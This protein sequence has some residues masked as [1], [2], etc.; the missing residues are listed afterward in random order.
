MK[1]DLSAQLNVITE[2]EDMTD[3]LLCFLQAIVPVTAV[4]LLAYQPETAQFVL[5]ASRKSGAAP[6]ADALPLPLPAGLD[7]HPAGG[8]L[9]PAG[10][11]LSA[12]HIPENAL[13][14]V[15]SLPLT[16]GE[17]LNA[18]LLMYLPP[19]ATLSPDQSDIL[20]HLAP[21]IAIAF[22][23]IQEHQEKLKVI[24]DRAKDAERHSISRDLHDMLGQNLA[25]LRL[26]LDQFARNIDRQTIDLDEVRAEL[27][28]MQ[29][30]A[31]RSYELVRSMLSILHTAEPLP[32]LDLLQNHAQTVAG[33]AGLSFEIRQ[34]DDPYVLKAAQLRQILFIFSEALSN[35]ERHAGAQSVRVDLVWGQTDLTMKIMDD[36]HGF[37]PNA[38]QTQQHFGLRIIQERTAVLGGQFDLRSTDHGT[39]LNFCFPL[40]ANNPH[41]AIPA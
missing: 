40:A 5:I 27:V 13:P 21:D 20:N 23:S 11:R 10:P 7:A 33:R 8:T 16:H 4:S 39:E 9:H 38:V 29:D 35:V 22:F 31:N 37:E 26:K 18:R 17:A 34:T 14:P 3:L 2:W 28:Y 32:L 24:V 41:H 36:G 15:Y 25:Y 19:G 12:G 1:H 6:A 30:I